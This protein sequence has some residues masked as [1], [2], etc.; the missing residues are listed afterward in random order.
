[1]T[2]IVQIE[3][4]SRCLYHTARL[5]VALTIAM[6]VWLLEFN[7][8]IA[9]NDTK[10]KNL[11]SPAKIAELLTLAGSDQPEE[12]KSG[13]ALQNLKKF[14]LAEH[15]VP[16]LSER[17]LDLESIRRQQAAARVLQRGGYT[18]TIDVLGHC[19]SVN[20]YTP[21]DQETEVAYW[22]LKRE[23]VKTIYELA[24]SQC[25]AADAD[26]NAVLDEIIPPTLRYVSA[27]KPAKARQIGLP[28]DDP[29]SDVQIQLHVDKQEWLLGEPVLLHYEVRNLGSE[30]AEVSFGGDSRTWPARSLRF[31]VLAIDEAGNVVDDPYPSRMSHGGGGG[32]SKLQ[33]EDNHWEPIPLWR[34]CAILRPGVYTIRVYHDLGWD[35]NNYFSK[36]ESTH[37][38]LIP[39]FAPVIETTLNFRE[40]TPD[41]ARGVVDRVLNMPRHPNRSLG[42]HAKPYGDMTALTHPVYLPILRERINQG[43]HFCVTAIGAMPFP[44][45]TETL[46]QLTSHNEQEVRHLAL[47]QL[48]NRLPN[49]SS[50]HK[51]RRWLA[52]HS[53]RDGLQQSAMALGWKLLDRPD[54]VTRGDIIRRRGAKILA[55]CGE[56]AD[57]ARYLEVFNEMIASGDKTGALNELLKAEFMLLE[58]RAISPTPAHLPAEGLMMLKAMNRDETFR[59]NGWEEAVDSLLKHPH[60]FVQHNVLA[61]MPHFVADRFQKQLIDMLNSPRRSQACRQLGNLGI[62]EAAEPLLDLLRTDTNSLVINVSYRAAAKCGVTL[63]RLTEICIDRMD[64]PDRQQTFFTLLLN[65]L[66]RKVGG[67]SASHVDWSVARD[68]KPRWQKL[69]DSNRE[70]IKAGERLEVGKPPVTHELFPRGFRLSLDDGSKWPDW[71]EIE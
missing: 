16:L 44:K 58:R 32:G 37:P 3:L 25:P 14:G 64:E 42:E 18:E 49:A 13:Q 65:V 11:V 30:Q 63:D 22:Q 67:W 8:A 40:P 51:N 38:P 26:S 50:L 70:G 5:A 1:M 35:G 47:E 28:K 34:S 52:K 29:R 12:A 21:G 46:I 59:P 45:A 57:T 48:V 17:A 71:S 6:V 62:P 4:S 54:D 66:D 41:E 56:T 60:A 39:H 53:W 2:R 7:H 20:R 68:L 15:V 55:A 33:P 10:G 23:L 31:K 36:I 27:L 19:L 43:N 9:Q 61:T 24:G 69:L